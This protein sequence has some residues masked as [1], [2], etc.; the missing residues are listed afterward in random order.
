[1]CRNQKPG[2]HLLRPRGSQRCKRRSWG[3][4]TRR[5]RKYGA[6]PRLG[7]GP[8]IQLRPSALLTTT[9]A[10]VGLMSSLKVK[11]MTLGG[12]DTVLSAEGSEL[13]SGVGRGNPIA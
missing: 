6:P 3:D 10:N 2:A 4:L 12:V 11:V 7:G 1:M 13:T 5:L 9:V 8:T